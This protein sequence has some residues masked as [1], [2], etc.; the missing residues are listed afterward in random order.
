MQRAVLLLAVLAGCELDWNFQNDDESRGF[1]PDAGADAAPDAPV[2]TTPILHYRFDDSLANDGTLGHDYDATGAS[3][4]YVEGKLGRAIAFDATWT[5]QVLLPTQELL[6]KP[7][8]VTIALW[9]REDS[10][11]SDGAVRYLFNNRGAGGF[12]T[13]HGAGG[14]QALTT[15]SDAGCAAF[16]Y[17]VGKWHQL[18]YRHAS[19]GALEIFIDGVLATTLPASNVYFSSTQTAIQI[20]TRTNMQVDELKI[21]D[22][23]V[24]TTD[25]QSL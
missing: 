25:L 13:Y 23:F 9:F 1:R 17:S 20:G 3:F 2:V 21:F 7:G 5:T 6:S 24:P 12:Q 14:N 10:V 19:G 16:G 4:T 8:D 18:V 15:C 11:Q 22:R